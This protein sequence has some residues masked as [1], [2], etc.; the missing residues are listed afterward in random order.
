MR[1]GLGGDEPLDENHPAQPGGP[2]GQPGR[3]MGQ[4]GRPMGQPIFQSCL[5]QEWETAAEA[6]S[7]VVARVVKMR[8][9]IVLGRDGGALPQPV[10]PIRLGLGAVLGNGKQWVSW[11]DI[12]DLVRLFEFALDTPTLRGALNAVSPGAVRHAQLQRVLAA[13]L[14]RAV[15]MRIPASILRTLIGEIHSC[16]SMDNT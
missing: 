14:R 1:H 2:M 13:V 6:A 11:I 15:W 3:P 12:D 4:P 9:G 7:G 16:W 10:M 8:I 5:R